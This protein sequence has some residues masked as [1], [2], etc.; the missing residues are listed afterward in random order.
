VIDT[1]GGAAQ[2]A[3]L[4]AERAASTSTW[5][6]LFGHHPYVS[7]G[8]HGN[9]AGAVETFFDDHVCGEFDVYFAGHDHNLQWLEDPCGIEPIVSGGGHSSYALI[10]TNATWFEAASTGFVWVE[11][12]GR[13]LTGVFY[14]K[15]GVELFRRTITK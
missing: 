14:D 15:D 2:E 8:P 9:A 3:W 5:N 11:I 12:D 7:N 13:D 4:P 1:G 6:I 10:G